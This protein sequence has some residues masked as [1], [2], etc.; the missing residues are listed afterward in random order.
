MTDY[1]TIRGNLGAS[2]RYVS[3]GSVAVVRFNVGSTE[4]RFNRQSN[5]WEDG[6]TNWHRVVVFR[7]QAHNV[8]V[9]LHKGMSVVIHG[10]IRNRRYNAGSEEAPEWRYTSEI[11]ADHVGVD[12][13]RGHVKFF[14]FT[15]HSPAVDGD[16]D[17]P[18]GEGTVA[19]GGLEEVGIAGEGNSAESPADA[20]TAAAD[21]GTAFHGEDAAVSSP[22]AASRSAEAE[23][24]DAPRAA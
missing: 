8:M 22:L 18:G 11:E 12:L 24:D 15:A 7:E 9:S 21:W 17:A 10:R 20:A 5:E 13:V 3:S 4:R 23:Q 14:P 6:H 1:V 2:P 16:D 19:P